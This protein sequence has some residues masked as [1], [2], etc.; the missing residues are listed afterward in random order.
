MTT[1]KYSSWTNLNIVDLLNKD[2]EYHLCFYEH[3]FIVFMAVLVHYNPKIYD[4]YSKLSNFLLSF[5]Y[6]FN[7]NGLQIVFDTTTLERNS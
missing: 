5:V 4:Y 7:I 3:N 1:T 6:G 2:N